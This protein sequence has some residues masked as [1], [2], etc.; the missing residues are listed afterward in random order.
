MSTEQKQPEQPVDEELDAKA[1]AGAVE[2]D[3]QAAEVEAELTAEQQLQAQLEAA[4]AKADENWDKFLRGQA[5]LDNVRKRAQRDVENARKFALEGIASELLPVRDSLELGLEAI[6][7]EDATVESA[8]D[9]LQL[10]QQMLAKLMDQH[11]IRA[12]DPAGENFNPEQHQAMSMQETTEQAANTVLAVMQKGYMLNER[13]LRPAMVVVAKAPT[14]A[15]QNDV[16]QP[17]A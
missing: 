12:V 11:G 13:L 7:K 8:K 3:E 10:I 16:D 9:G 17:E 2:P 4:Q 5:E 14:Q 15:E 6:C 1:D